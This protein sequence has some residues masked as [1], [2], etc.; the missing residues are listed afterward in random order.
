MQFHSGTSVLSLNV[1]S[2]SKSSVEQTATRLPLI[3]ELSF[4]L[5]KTCKVIA[6]FHK[7]K[8]DSLPVFLPPTSSW[9]S[10]CYCMVE[11]F[12]C[13][14]SWTTTWSKSWKVHR[15][16][17]CEGYL[18]TITRT[19]TSWQAGT[20]CS[21]TNDFPQH[22]TRFPIIGA[23][24]L[25]AMKPK[26]ILQVCSPHNNLSQTEVQAC[27]YNK[28]Y[29]VTFFAWEGSSLNLSLEFIIFHLP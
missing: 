21:W 15:L 7:N 3:T 11:H 14:L 12:S 2:W 29:N 17:W 18:Q 1:T 24:R 4:P 28:L 16:L 25:V 9:W 26:R 19:S 27:I 13:L 23:H 6:L 20:Y 8:T 22:H 5:V 10:I